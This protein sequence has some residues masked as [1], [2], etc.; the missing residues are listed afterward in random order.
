MRSLPCSPLLP[1][2][3]ATLLAIGMLLA[4]CAQTSGQQA[5]TPPASGPAPAASVSAPHSPAPPV[6]SS[7]PLSAEPLTEAA[8]GVTVVQVQVSA[9]QVQGGVQRVD[10]ALGTPVRIHVVADV[11][12]DVHLHGYERRVPVAPGHP[13][14][15]EFVADIPGVFE[16]EL[17]TAGLRLVELRVQ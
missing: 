17:E 10:V 9:G 4:G 6:E 15:V 12:D 11:A 2:P 1:R 8:H 3:P 7:A 5:A 14:A 16:A 13:A